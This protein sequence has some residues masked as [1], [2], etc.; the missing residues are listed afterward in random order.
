MCGKNELF[1]A[2]DETIKFTM[3]VGNN[4]NIPIMGKDQITIR[5][6]DD[7]QNFISNVN[8]YHNLLSIG[9]LSEKGYNMQIHHGYYTL[10]DQN[11]RFVAKVKTSLNRLF[12]L[13]IH[14][15][16]LS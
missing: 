13:R 15:E 12:S 2:L 3:R 11:R 7:Y 5:L 4:V 6:K 1:S 8:I 10:I 14:Q 9:Q 16:K